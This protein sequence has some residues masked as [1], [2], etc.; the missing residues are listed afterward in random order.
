MALLATGRKICGSPPTP[1]TPSFPHAQ[2]LDVQSETRAVNKDSSPLLSPL[3]FLCKVAKLSQSSDYST[4]KAD[5]CVKLLQSCPNLWD[6]MDC[7]LQAP[8]SMGFSRQEYWSGFPFPPPGDL[9]D[10]GT[11]P[12]SLTSPALAGR[13]FTISSTWNTLT[14]HCPNKADRNCNLLKFY[15]FIYLLKDYCF[16]EFCCFLSNLNMNQP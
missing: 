11:E 14:P 15:L 7:S 13:F 2:L 12:T 6:P 4:D 8:L 5:V 3:L 1:G 9:P 10:L 16:T